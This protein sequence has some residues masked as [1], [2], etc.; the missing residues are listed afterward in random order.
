MCARATSIKTFG[1]CKG[2]KESEVFSEQNAK[3]IGAA[4]AYEIEYIFG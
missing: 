1:K 2:P 3:G 4:K